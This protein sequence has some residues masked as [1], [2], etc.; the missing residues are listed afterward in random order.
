[1]WN[2]GIEKE[3]ALD[4]V[5]WMDRYTALGIKPSDPICNKCDGIGYHPKGMDIVKCDNCGGTGKGEYV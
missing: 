1:M 4:K 3:K 5:E 2:M